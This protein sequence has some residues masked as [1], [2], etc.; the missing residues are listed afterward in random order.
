M[1]N[2]S[3]RFL[4]HDHHGNDDNHKDDNKCAANHNSYYDSQSHSIG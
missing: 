4:L 2:F 1:L 3:S